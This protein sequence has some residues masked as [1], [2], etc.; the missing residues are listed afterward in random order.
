MTDL[1][2]VPDLN[3][4]QQVIMDGGGYRLYA[5]KMGKDGQSEGLRFIADGTRIPTP[6]MRQAIVAASG[7]RLREEDV[8]AVSGFLRHTTNAEHQ[9]DPHWSEDDDK[10]KVWV[11]TKAARAAREQRLA[12]KRAAK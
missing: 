12:N 7:G 3:I 8:V 5:R 1:A 11:T 9:T 10:R 2:V 4:V 6:K